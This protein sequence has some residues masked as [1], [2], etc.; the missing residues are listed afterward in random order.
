MDDTIVAL[1]ERPQEADAVR[2][3]LIGAGIE[4]TNISVVT[5]PPLKE[6][7]RELAKSLLSWFGDEPQEESRSCVVV[8]DGPD[9]V[10]RAAQI[11]ERHS[12]RDVKKQA[13]A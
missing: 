10:R 8:Y 13:A 7:P 1:F 9:Q 6:K 2:Q 4:N 11:I 12:P 5:E 3:D